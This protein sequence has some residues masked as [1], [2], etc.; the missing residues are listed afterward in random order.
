MLVRR[1]SDDSP[2]TAPERML[3][4]FPVKSLVVA[5]LSKAPTR[6]AEREAMLGFRAADSKSLLRTES[7]VEYQSR[8]ATETA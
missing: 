7:D 8:S 2:F 6:K 1:R 3:A 4:D 5:H